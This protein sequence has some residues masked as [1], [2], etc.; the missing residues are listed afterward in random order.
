M[1][2]LPNQPV[3]PPAGYDPLIATL[4]EELEREGQVGEPLIFE[5]PVQ[6]QGRFFAVVVW[7]AWR[8][9]P[10]R[11]RAAIILEAYRRYDQAHPDHPKAPQL[12]MAT[13]MTWEEADQRGLFPF[14]ITP[15]AHPD[16]V[17][18]QAVRDAL[19]NEG[20]IA[21]A[22]GLKLRFASREAAQQA[23]QRLQE[24]LPQAHWSLNQIVGTLEED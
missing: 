15:N 5:N 4:A 10:V 22:T 2:V 14:S 9:V 16:E 8:A 11:Q 7:S 23:F 24:R 6:A 3:T 20:A 12:A 21:T 17:D 18:S 13:G 19:R 1:P